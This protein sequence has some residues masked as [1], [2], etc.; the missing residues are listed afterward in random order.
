MRGKVVIVYLGDL[1][2]HARVHRQIGFLASE[3]DVTVAS[4]GPPPDDVGGEWV[5]LSEGA[6]RSRSGSAGRAFLRVAGRYETAYWRD[7]QTRAW[8]EELKVLM[9]ADAIVVNQLYALPLAFALGDGV[10]VVF[11]AHEHW[12]SESASWSWR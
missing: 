6:A 1:A 10:P 12:T 3:Y 7:P 5:R 4:F 8:R 2:N 11:D 9:P